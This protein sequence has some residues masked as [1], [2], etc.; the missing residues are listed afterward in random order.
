MAYKELACAVIYQAFDDIK[1]YA[2]SKDKYKQEYMR[3]NKESAKKFLFSDQLD[4]YIRT[5]ELDLSA[6]FLRREALKLC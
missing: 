6:D 3:V 4:N 5:Y 2:T 1:E